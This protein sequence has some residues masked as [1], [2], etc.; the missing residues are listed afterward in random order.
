MTIAA[1]D[2]V[3]RVERIS[4]LLPPG[5]VTKQISGGSGST[6]ILGLPVA[7]FRLQG[8]TLAYRLL[9]IRDELTP[10]TDGSW[11]GR[12]LLLGRELRF[13]SRSRPPQ[14]VNTKRL[15]DAAGSNTLCFAVE[16]SDSD[17]HD[18]RHAFLGGGACWG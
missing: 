13:A 1:L 14:A 4:G 12:G 2:G 6:R 9:P 11:E 17:A 10:K 16:S 15:E 18:A 5:G 3:W 7:L 8:Q